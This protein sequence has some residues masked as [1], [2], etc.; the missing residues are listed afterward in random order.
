MAYVAALWTAPVAWGR[1]PIVGN[2][3]LEILSERMVKQPSLLSDDDDG[4]HRQP[5][6]NEKLIVR[7]RTVGKRNSR[8][9]FG[10]ASSGVGSSSSSSAD[11]SPTLPVDGSKDEEFTG[12]FIFG[13]DEQGRIASHT[14]EHVEED[15]GRTCE[16]KTTR[17]VSVTDWLLGR[18]GGL[19][20]GPAPP[21][22]VAAC[23]MVD[24]GAGEEF[25]RVG[26]RGRRG[27]GGSC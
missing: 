20:G 18:L 21:P 23:V 11:L 4:N 5:H 25:R 1:V 26:C 17:F 8:T 9:R 24:A 10:T 22:A 14:I 16:E 3:R 27:S 13:F 7:W 12:L 19:A 15:G 2:V 6:Q